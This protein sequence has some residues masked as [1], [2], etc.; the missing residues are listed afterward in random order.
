V[1]GLLREEREDGGPHVAAPAT[2]PAATPAAVTAPSG[3]AAPAETGAGTTGAPT[4]GAEATG[5]E[6]ARAEATRT[7]AAR[8]GATRAGTTGPGTVSRADTEAG[9][10]I[11]PAGATTARTLGGRPVVTVGGRRLVR[12]A[13]SRRRSVERGPEGMSGS[14]AEP[15]A[16]SWVGSSAGSW[17]ERRRAAGLEGAAEGTTA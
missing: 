4:A 7:E 6:A 14:G 9:A 10:E 3:T 8:T 2:A 13:V 15:R 5:T 12:R 11:T 17:A 1:A 16:E